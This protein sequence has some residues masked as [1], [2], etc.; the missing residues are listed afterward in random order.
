MPSAAHARVK[1]SVEGSICGDGF[2]KSLTPSMSKNL[3]PGMRRSQC[4]ID[5]LRFKSGMCHDA[6]R[7]TTS[8]NLSW[9]HS[10][11]TSALL[12]VSMDDDDADVAN[13]LLFAFTRVDARA[14]L[15]SIIRDG[16]CRPIADAVQLFT[17]ARMR[18]V[19]WCVSQPSRR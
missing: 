13:A 3:A 14:F 19:E 12:R 16:V 11:L 7:T 6:S 10:G 18:G 2:L 1:A 17:V 8:F 15:R 9:S 4:S 5:P